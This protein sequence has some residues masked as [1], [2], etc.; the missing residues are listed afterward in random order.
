MQ[1][2]LPLAFGFLFPSF[3]LLNFPPKV[4]FGQ[5]HFF[6]VLIK[7]PLFVEASVR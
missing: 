4:A 1:S 6:P 2:L 7:G 3:C 5:S